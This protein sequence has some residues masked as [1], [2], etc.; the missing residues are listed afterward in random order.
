M[1]L[2]GRSRSLY[3]RYQLPEAVLIGQGAYGTVKGVGT[4]AIKYSAQAKHEYQ[5][6]KRLE[7]GG[8]A[9]FVRYH[10]IENNLVSMEWIQ[11]RTLTESLKEMEPAQRADLARQ[12]ATSFG[13]AL[14]AGIFPVDLHQDNA[15]VSADNQLTFID[16]GMYE[17]APLPSIFEAIPR[18]LLSLFGGG[19]SK[20]IMSWKEDPEYIWQTLAHFLKEIAPEPLRRELSLEISTRAIGLKGEMTAE[21]YE[22]LLDGLA[23]IGQR[24]QL[25]SLAN[26]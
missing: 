26:N 19:E 2:T 22:Q 23:W 1:K 24:C 10:Q 20:E 4:T 11:G 25:F 8:A 3:E 17:T 7:E 6:A 5:V 14:R 12:A 18:R 21:R 9:G 15:L 13:G 16:F